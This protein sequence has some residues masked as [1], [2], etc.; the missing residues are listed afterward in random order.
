VAFPCV[1]CR[2]V[3]LLFWAWKREGIRRIT[4]R[5]LRSARGNQCNKSSGSTRA[6]YDLGGECSSLSKVERKYNNPSPLS[7]SFAEG[8]RLTALSTSFAQ[9]T[10][11][12]GEAKDNRGEDGGDWRAEE[13]TPKWESTGKEGVGAYLQAGVA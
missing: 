13:S 7:T 11:K 4:V 2:L 9:T 10:E 3:S 6:P 8:H 12:R 1:C 5:P